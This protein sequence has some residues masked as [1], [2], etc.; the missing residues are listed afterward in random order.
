MLH[1]MRAPGDLVDEVCQLLAL[2]TGEPASRSAVLAEVASRGWRV[3]TDPPDVPIVVVVPA[4]ATAVEHKLVLIFNDGHGLVGLVTRLPAIGP[5]PHLPGPAVR[6]GMAATGLWGP[7]DRRGS[8]WMTWVGGM[9]RGE[10]RQNPDQTTS[11]WW[12]HASAV[13]LLDAEQGGGTEP[14]DEIDDLVQLTAVLDEWWPCAVET[15]HR[16]M[17]DRMLATW[18]AAQA[19]PLVV[20]ATAR[21]AGVRPDRVPEARMR[22]AIADFGKRLTGEP[23]GDIQPG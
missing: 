9:G 16:L 18:A 15:A 2:W 6:V 23:G 5:A 22:E 10:V 3:Q 12:V 1:G 11:V 21:A 4:W 14:G 7:A 17:G 19:T 8:G 13:G 20:L